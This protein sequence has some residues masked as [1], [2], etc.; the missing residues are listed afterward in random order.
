MGLK[1]ALEFAAINWG[2][3]RVTGFQF[4]KIMGGRGTPDKPVCSIGEG[5]LVDD[6][7]KDIGLDSLPLAP[8][9]RE[10]VVDIN[11]LSEEDGMIEFLAGAEVLSPFLHQQCIDAFVRGR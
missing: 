11:I 10:D 1:I 3:C 5:G 4:G 7:I 9:L 6:R 2:R 8:V